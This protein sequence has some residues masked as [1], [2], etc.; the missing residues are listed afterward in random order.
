MKSF[1]APGK[2]LRVLRVFTIVLLVLTAAVLLLLLL[3]LVP[4]LIF[5][6]SVQIESGGFLDLLLQPTQHASSIIEA[7][8]V[9][10]ASLPLLLAAALLLALWIVLLVRAYGG[11]KQK[12]KTP[13]KKSGR[14]KEKTTG[15]RR[16]AAVYALGAVCSVLSGVSCTQLFIGEYV[17]LLFFADGLFAFYLLYRHDP[18]LCGALR[19]NTEGAEQHQ[20]RG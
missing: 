4:M 1:A 19:L 10:L 16:A 14:K 9:F 7:K 5:G 2:G 13:A 3:A 17:K 15:G 20:K 8:L 6:G 18:L 12:K 11:K